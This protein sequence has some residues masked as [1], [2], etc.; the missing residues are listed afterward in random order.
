MTLGYPGAVGCTVPQIHPS[1]SYIAIINNNNINIMIINNNNINNNNNNNN[2][3]IIN[4]A[5]CV[6]GCTVE[7]IDMS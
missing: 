3:M 2:I 1:A 7:Q 5:P 6:E 4:L